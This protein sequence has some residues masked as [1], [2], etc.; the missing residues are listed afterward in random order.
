MDARDFR[1]DR[2]D[3]GAVGAGH[4]VTAV[5]ELKLWPEKAGRLATVHVRYKT[6]DGHWAREMEGTADDRCLRPRFDA[7]S[8]SFKLAA[9]V[10]EFAE[11]LRGSPGAREVRLADVAALA[12]ECRAQ[13][14]DRAELGEFVRLVETACALRGDSRAAGGESEEE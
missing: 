9:A 10:S 3:G 13:R 14:G 8:D 4:S 11:V 6:A 7:A 5:Y 1:N 12:R 2:V